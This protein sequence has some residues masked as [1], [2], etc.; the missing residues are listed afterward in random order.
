MTP[1]YWN[2]L[3]SVFRAGAER[4]SGWVFNSAM[5]QQAQIMEV[6]ANRCDEI[7]DELSNGSNES[8]PRYEQCTKCDTKWP[9][10]KLA[11]GLCPRCFRVKK[12]VD[13]MMNR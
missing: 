3:A 12:Q 8:G 11:Q 10:S 2:D 9:I 4:A 5:Q 6:M 7:S 13:E 1:E